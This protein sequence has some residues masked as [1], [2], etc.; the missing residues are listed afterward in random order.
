MPTTRRQ[1]P[2]RSDLTL[3]G[4][5]VVQTCNIAH[6][7]IREKT[8]RKVQPNRRYAIMRVLSTSRSTLASL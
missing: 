6:E 1:T 4:P 8:T 2:S 7:H 3:V 5:T